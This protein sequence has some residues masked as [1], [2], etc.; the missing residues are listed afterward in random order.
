MFGADVKA[1]PLV[2]LAAQ[3]PASPAICLVGI[4]L[5]QPGL[6]PPPFSPPCGTCTGVCLSVCLVFNPLPWASPCHLRS[7]HH[8]STS[9]SLL[10][11]S[12]SPT[13]P[14]RG[15]LPPPPRCSRILCTAPRGEHSPTPMP[16]L[17]QPSHPCPRRCPPSTGPISVLTQWARLLQSPFILFSQPLYSSKSAAW[18][19]PFNG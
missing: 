19:D 8:L 6:V 17:L 11:S 5:P 9:F 10:L 4:S 2:P 16:L 12:L 7:S 1:T 18:L 13:V 3:G 14:P 15:P